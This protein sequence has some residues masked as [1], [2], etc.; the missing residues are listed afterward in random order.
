MASLPDHL[1][2]KPVGR[3]PLSP[4]IREAHQ[5]DRVLLAATEV[6]AK[7]GFRATTVDHI[8]AA[9]KIGVGSFY[10]LFEG[11]D[12]CFLQLFDQIV[13]GAEEQIAA[14]V[15]DDRSWSERVCLGLRVA[16]EVVATDPRRAGIVIVQAH[17]AGDAVEARYAATLERLTDIL[18]GGRS[19]DAN[20][21][22]LPDGF[23][24]ATVAGVAWLLYQRLAVGDPVDASELFPETVRIVVAPYVGEAVAEQLIADQ[25][26][27]RV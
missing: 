4:A 12:D 26:R 3:E 5:R 6:F 2:S 1:S 7:R 22:K 10:G 21:A 27:A 24:H 14:A 13:A 17:S 16:L 20:G 23:E 25:A 18:R 8:V 11:K 15:S 9:A 19:L